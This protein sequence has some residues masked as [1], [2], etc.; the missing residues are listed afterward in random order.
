MSTIVQLVQG[1]PQWHEHR[2]LLRNASETPAVLGIS[3]WVTPY[4]LWLL[5]TGRAEQ[6]VNA[7]MRNGTALEPLARHAYEVETGHVMQ[8]LV[9]Q[10]GAYSASLDGITLDGGLILEIKVPYKGQSSALWQ[11]VEGGE[12]PGHYLAQIQHQLMVSG[13]RLAHLWVFDGQRG[14]LREIEADEGAWSGI[15]DAW[16]AFWPFVEGDSPPPLAEADTVTRDD[17]AWRAAAT[18]YLEAKRQADASTEALDAARERLVALASHPRVQGHGVSV[19]RYWKAGAVDYKRV[20]ELQG[21]DL[22]RYRGRARQEVRVT[23]A[24]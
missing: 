16:D 15:R 19:T 5:K 6:P 4:Q 13:A 20:P 10:A 18:A 22:E 8:P 24:S 9:L 11:A 3:P 7:A 23:T 21:V 12:I 2:R 14:L 1:S 17:D